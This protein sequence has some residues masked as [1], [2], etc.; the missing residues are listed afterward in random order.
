MLW[1]GGGRVVCPASNTVPAHRKCSRSSSCCLHWCA[2]RRGPNHIALGVGT[3]RSGH[4]CSECL[5]DSAA[6]QTPVRVACSVPPESLRE[7]SLCPV[8]HVRSNTA[9]AP[10][11][12]GLHSP[13]PSAT[14]CLGVGALPL[15]P[16]LPPSLHS[17]GQPGRSHSA[18]DRWP[19]GREGHTAEGTRCVNSR[20]G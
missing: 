20:R 2:E 18:G 16:V 9:R 3:L 15:C 13:L 12:Q 6:V 14:G 1:W 5:P 8:S 17:Q 11:S 4:P 10:H 19:A 7:R